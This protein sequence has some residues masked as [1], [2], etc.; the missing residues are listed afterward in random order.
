M[1]YR[2]IATHPLLHRVFGLQDICKMTYKGD[3]HMHDFYHNLQD[4]IDNRSPTITDNDIRDTL[5]TMLENKSEALKDE[6]KEFSK[7]MTWS[8]QHDKEPPKPEFSRDFP[9]R[10]MRDYLDK[11]H[12]EANRYAT[13]HGKSYRLLARIAIK[14]MDERTLQHQRNLAIKLRKRNVLHR[15]NK[16]D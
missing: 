8:M 13:L 4:V 3:H 7:A 11:K 1:L 10:S 14:V 12:Q 2:F 6:L 15:R 9:M 5:W 16:G